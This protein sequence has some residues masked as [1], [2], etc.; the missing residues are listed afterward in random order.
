MP[1]PPQEL[2]P[3]CQHCPERPLPLLGALAAAPALPYPS[4]GGGACR[5]VLHVSILRVFTLAKLQ[6]VTCGFKPEMML[7]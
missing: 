6:V 2:T 4:M 5:R 1:S 3:A 7:G